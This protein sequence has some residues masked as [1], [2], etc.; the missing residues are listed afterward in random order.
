MPSRAGGSRSAYVPQSA[1]QGG[2]CWLS[3][4]QP[5]KGQIG[6]SAGQRGVASSGKR[7]Q[8]GAHDY[9]N[10][11]DQRISACRSPVTVARRAAREQQAAVMCLPR[12]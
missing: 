11:A 4:A 10:R 1:A 3:A 8:R 6:E 12:R 9:G 7:P 2:F 5:F